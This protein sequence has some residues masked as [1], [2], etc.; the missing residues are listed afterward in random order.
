MK[1]ENIFVINSHIM[2]PIFFFYTVMSEWNKNSYYWEERS[3]TKSTKE[4]IT[5]LLVQIKV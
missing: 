1:T 3:F 5:E 2:Y 4:R